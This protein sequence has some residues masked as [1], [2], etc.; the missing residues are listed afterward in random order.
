MDWY[1]RKVLSWPISNTLDTGFCVEALKEAIFLYGIPNIFN[2]DQGS[3]FTSMSFT[4]VLKDHGI[5]IS[6]DGKGRWM[7]NI[8]IER[9][10]RSLKYKCVYLHNFDNGRQAKTTIGSWIGHYNMERPH[11]TF[12]CQTPHEV[13]VKGTLYGGTA[14]Y[15]KLA[16]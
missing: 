15:I 16:A 1:S 9:L 7:D 5:T 4:G 6:M 12:D 2:T 11:S 14:S 3:Q 8:F 13:Y 10:C